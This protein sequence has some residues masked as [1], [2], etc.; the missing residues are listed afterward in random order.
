M[1]YK[2]VGS[3]FCSI[4]LA[5]EGFAEEVEQNHYKL[6]EPLNTWVQPVLKEQT[7]FF[8][9][10]WHMDLQLVLTCRHFKCI[11]P[12]WDISTRLSSGCAWPQTLHFPS[13]SGYLLLAWTISLSLSLFLSTPHF[14]SQGS[15]SW[16]PEHCHA[17]SRKLQGSCEVCP[18]WLI[19]AYRDTGERI[20]TN[21]I[22]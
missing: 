5:D 20:W 15:S 4:I 7:N 2:A 8:T 1:C 22:R 11:L 9:C 10:P 14:P 6:P 19:K 17:N 16:W 13:G 21:S 12:V 3:W 18:H